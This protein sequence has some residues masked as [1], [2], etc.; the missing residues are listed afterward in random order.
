MIVSRNSIVSLH[1]KLTDSNGNLLESTEGSEPLEYMHESSGLLP[2]LES[3]LT[4]HQAGDVVSVKINHVE[5]YGE[6]HAELVQVIPLRAFGEQAP[7][8]DTMFKAKGKDGESQLLKITE[9]HES[10]VVV[11][12]NHPLAGLDL[13]F[14]V[15]VVSVREPTVD[16]LEAGDVLNQK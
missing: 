9:V 8:V 1:F 11:D 16:E 2:A 4:G 12:A 15:G 13:V 5:A 7:V 6:H 3:A 10:H 14:D